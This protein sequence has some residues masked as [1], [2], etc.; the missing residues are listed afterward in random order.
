M[1]DPHSATRFAVYIVPPAEHPFYR[2]GSSLLGH[3]VRARERLPLPDFIRPEWQSEASPYGLHLTVVE[4]FYTE[5]SKLDAIEAEAR[6]CLACLSP[7][8]GLTLSGGHLD[9]WD[10][11]AVWVQRYTPTPALLVLHT[12]LLSRLSPFVSASPFDKEVQE[13]KWQRPFEQARMK[14]LHTPRGLDTFE[15]HFTLVQPYSGDDPA[16]LRRELE[17]LTRFFSELEVNQLALCVKP[18]GEEN[19]Q[20][21]AEF[22]SRGA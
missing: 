1:T 21:R 22:G 4:G 2:L 11:G 14:L 19:W 12:L 16:S 5:A 15:P 18:Q 3:D 20:I 13:G 9:V 7:G 8:A 6:A 10:G 17:A